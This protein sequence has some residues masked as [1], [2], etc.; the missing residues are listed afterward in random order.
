MGIV[1]TDNLSA[2]MVTGEDVKDI[3]GRLL[4]KKGNP[5]GSD[6]IRMFKMWGIAEV[7][8]SGQQSEKSAQDV[9]LD[10]Q[11]VEAVTEKEMHHFRHVDLSHPAMAELFQLSVHYRCH[12]PSPKTPLAKPMDSKTP[13]MKNF[14]EEWRRQINDGGIKLP[15]IPSIIY[16]LNE[17]ISS[18]NSS[19]ISIAQVVSK[20]PSLAALL[21]RI[22]NSAFYSFPSQIDN[23]SKA[24]TLI[25]TKEITGL[26][27][28]ISIINNFKDIPCDMMDMNAFLKHSFAC[29]IL[30]RILAAQKNIPYTEQLFVSG[31]L[32]DIGRLI[33]FKY[34]QEHTRYLL[35]RQVTE[36]SI[37][38]VEEGRLLGYRHTDIGRDLLR[39]WKL[40]LAIENNI[41]YHHHPS[42]AAG[43]TQAAIIHLADIM[44]SGMGLGTSGAIFV[45]PLDEA[46]WEKLAIS[47]TSFSTAFKQTL[48][49][50]YAFESSINRS[51]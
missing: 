37:L 49:Q 17:V 28:G 1:R 35:Q 24:V 43:P 46:A 34:F 32:H 3:N 40:P 21:L 7:V 39:K 27:L 12:H 41:F 22:V 23:I 25:G 50:L 14:K 38:V 42:N 29:G 18:P 20:S 4:L 13:E 33:I 10:P 47:P 36:E 2:E 26:A 5:I 31:L 6:H 19:A 45:P 11:L 44:V 30:S 15:E 16:E 9:D 48:H 51:E 8:I